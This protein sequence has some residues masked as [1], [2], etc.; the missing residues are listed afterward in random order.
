MAQ[1]VTIPVDPALRERVREHPEDF[2]FPPDT[3]EA[4]IYA[5]L[6]EVG[7][8]AVLEERRRAERIKLYDEWADDPERHQAVREAMQM[9]IEDGLL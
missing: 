6:V 4:R 2:G 3:S 8:R 5:R 9:A 1:R 7:A